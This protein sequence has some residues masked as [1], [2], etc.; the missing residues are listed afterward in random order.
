MLRRPGNISLGQSTSVGRGLLPLCPFDARDCPHSS[1]TRR[2]PPARD[3]HA[4][5]HSASSHLLFFGDL[6]QRQRL[7]IHLHSLSKL[8]PPTQFL[9][10]FRAS[11]PNATLELHHAPRYRSIRSESGVALLFA[12]RNGSKAAE[13]AEAPS[14]C[15]CVFHIN[16]IIAAESRVLPVPEDHLSPEK[17]TCKW[18]KLRSI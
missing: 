11:P 16:D 14:Q 5:F 1:S 10:Y 6:S 3:Q 7:R 9:E 18:E 15:F 17:V 4:S 8:N 12:I 13:P 2:K